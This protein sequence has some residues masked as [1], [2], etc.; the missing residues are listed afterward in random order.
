[1]RQS[2]RIFTTANFGRPLVTGYEKN[3]F[4][5]ES[6]GKQ[7]SALKP[8][9]CLGDVPRSRSWSDVTHGRCRSSEQERGFKMRIQNGNKLKSR[10]FLVKNPPRNLR[11]QRLKILFLNL[12][13]GT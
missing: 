10:R 8:V 3:M 11:F 6:I 5:I 12:L 1:M 9:N 4:Q 7:V 2:Q 13:R